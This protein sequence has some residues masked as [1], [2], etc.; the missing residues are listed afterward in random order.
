MPR[1]P[2]VRVIS[3]G[4]GPT[5]GG[6]VELW[7][8]RLVAEANRDPAHESH[9]ALAAISEGRRVTIPRTSALS[10]WTWITIK[11]LERYGRAGALHLRRCRECSRWFTSWHGRS[12]VCRRALCH[13]AA[14]A[15][16]QASR[17][18]ATHALQRGALAGVTRKR[19][20]GTK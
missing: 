3:T 1:S 7:I 9:P 17:R 12:I 16:R 14:D 15:R 11:H 13:T 2:L 5:M 20:A 19:T 18:K 4:D 8:A 10:P 6:N